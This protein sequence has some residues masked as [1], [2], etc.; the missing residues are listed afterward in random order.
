MKTNSLSN[1]SNIQQYCANTQSARECG[2]HE[3]HTHTNLITCDFV[4]LRGI[5]TFRVNNEIVALH[6]F[7][8]HLPSSTA[9]D[10]TIVLA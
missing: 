9:L 6:L 10:V 5:F 1:I 2:N 3:N 8:T 4:A 7:Y